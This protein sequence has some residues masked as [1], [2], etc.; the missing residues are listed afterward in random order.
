M[1]LTPML[2]WGL[3]IWYDSKLNI[4]HPNIIVLCSYL[5]QPSNSPLNYIHWDHKIHPPR[6][7]IMVAPNLC[8]QHPLTPHLE[9]PPS[10]NV[11]LVLYPTI[12]TFVSPFS[13]SQG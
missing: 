11:M 4:A 5:R 1:K 8:L 6:Q 12:R 9:N 13:A 3:K 2:R 10:Q 7:G